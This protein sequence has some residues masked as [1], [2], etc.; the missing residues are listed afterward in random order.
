MRKIEM[1]AMLSF[2]RGEHFVQK[3]TRVTPDGRIELF[4][5]TIVSTRP[6]GFNQLDNRSYVLTLAGYPTHTTR[7]RLNAFLKYFCN[8]H[9]GF[10]QKRG[11]QYFGNNEINSE[12]KVILDYKFNVV[13]IE[14]HS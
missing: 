2:K 6:E 9:Y 10:R 5:N 8:L 4:G 11:Q 13:G 1:D 14:R 12:D 3:N 7:S